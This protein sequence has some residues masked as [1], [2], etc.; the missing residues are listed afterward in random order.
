MTFNWGKKFTE[1]QEKQGKLG[2]QKA[3]ISRSFIAHAIDQA[4]AEQREIDAKIAEGMNVG[5]EA[6][7]VLSLPKF[8]KRDNEMFNGGYNRAVADIAKSIREAK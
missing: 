6:G 5:E 7:F 3:L 4:K 2:T 1:L 8:V